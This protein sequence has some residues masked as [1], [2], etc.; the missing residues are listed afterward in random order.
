MSLKSAGCLVLFLTLVGCTGTRPAHLG[1]ARVQLLQ[2]PDKPNCVSSLAGEDSARAVPSLPVGASAA[3][4]MSRLREVVASMP[5]SQIIV[6][7]DHYL[8]AEFTSR[9]M[10]FVDDVEFL[11][12]AGVI[13]VRSASRLGHADFGV[14]Q[15]R[16]ASIREK[17]AAAM[18]GSSE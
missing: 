3:V 13:H 10:Q 7:T 5:G 9:L 11:H 17:Y 1:E 12:Q 18:Q 2:C 6:Q 16:V 8:Y 15:A 14:N 4:A